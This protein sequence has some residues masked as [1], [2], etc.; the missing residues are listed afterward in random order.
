[1]LGNGLGTRPQR[2]YFLEIMGLVFIVGNRAPV[3]VQFIFSRSPACGIHIG[4]DPVDPVRRKK[5][6]YSGP[7]FRQSLPE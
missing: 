7:S 5:A 2:D 4:D 1:M 3:A 6:I